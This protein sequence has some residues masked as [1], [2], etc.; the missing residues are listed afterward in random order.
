MTLASGCSPIP[1]LPVTVPGPPPSPST[2]AQPLTW[3]L[4]ARETPAVPPARPSG[5][6]APLQPALPEE[7][8]AGVWPPRPAGAPPLGWTR[9]PFFSRHRLQNAPLVPAVGSGE[10]SKC[11]GV[12][13]G[14]RQ[15]AHG[16]C[17][18]SAQGCPL[19]PGLQEH[20]SPFLLRAQA[21]ASPGRTPSPATAGPPPT[22]GRLHAD[23]LP[24]RHS[25]P[26]QPQHPTARRLRPACPEPR[27]A[28]VLGG[29]APARPAAAH[30]D[31]TPARHGLPHAP[32]VRLGTSSRR[33]DPRATLRAAGQDVVGARPADPRSP[34]ATPMHRSTAWHPAVSRVPKGAPA[35]PSPGCSVQGAGARHPTARPFLPTRSLASHGRKPEQPN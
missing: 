24:C 29:S 32:S 10:G 12:G 35:A 20:K 19:S 25:A 7:C 8:R 27:R 21:E 2:P 18:P 23:R 15:T 3:L 31:P 14:Y 11:Q 17:A 5:G 26:G 9:Q 34:K 30:R 28:G 4:T 1:T 6:A 13:L 16:P 22:P 33:A